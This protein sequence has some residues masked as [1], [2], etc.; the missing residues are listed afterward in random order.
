MKKK[1]LYAIAMKINSCSDQEIEKR[2]E[3]I[4]DASIRR[5]LTLAELAE[6]NFI[7]LKILSKK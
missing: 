1:I 6:L 7:C 4:E 5:K 2:L 3:D